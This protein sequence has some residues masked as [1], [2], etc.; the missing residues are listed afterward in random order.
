VQPRPISHP[1]SVTAEVTDYVSFNDVTAATETSHNVVQPM[2]RSYTLYVFCVL[3]DSNQWNII[4]CRRVASSN[5]T[6]NI[7]LSLAV[8]IR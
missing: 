2:P 8:T 5:S 3:M 6:A 7:L 1:I 4:R